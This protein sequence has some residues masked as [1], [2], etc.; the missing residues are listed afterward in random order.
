MVTSP[1]RAWWAIFWFLPILV[2]ATPVCSD[3]PTQRTQHPPVRWMAFHSYLRDLATA[4]RFGEEPIPKFPLPLGEGWGEGKASSEAIEKTSS[5]SS[6]PHP[7][8][9][10]RRTGEG[11]LWDSLELGIHTVTCFPANTLSS[12]GVPYSPY[13]PIW[14][15]P[16]M[17]D[18]ALLDRQF[19]E[20]L[21][22]NPRA[23]SHPFAPAMYEDR[24][25]LFGKDVS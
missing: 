21:A 17:Y 16:N 15:G 5:D 9:L 4:K 20:I 6:H 1:C 13:P 8:P 10:S 19:Q 3:E 24:R 25:T 23:V 14:L 2:C 11:R 12:V 22:A 18:F 7:R